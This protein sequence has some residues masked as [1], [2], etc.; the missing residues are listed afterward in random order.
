ML[1]RREAFG[2]LAAGMGLAV[3]RPGWAARAEDDK[4][5]RG[6]I[7][8]NPVRNPR[9]PAGPITGPVAIDPADGSWTQVVENMYALGVSTDGRFVYGINGGNQPAG[10]WSVDLKE[11]GEPRKIADERADRVWST[12]GGKIILST[13]AFRAQPRKAWRINPDGSG[14]EDLPIPDTDEVI[15]ASADGRWLLTR[16]DRGAPKEGSFLR[17][18]RAIYRMRPDGGDECLVLEA[19]YF[20]ATHRL[21]P[22]G[23]TVIYHHIEG[24]TFEGEKDFPKSSIWLVGS[25]GKGRRLLLKNPPGERYSQAVWSPDSKRLAVRLIRRPDDLDEEVKILPLY[26]AVCRIDVVDLEGKRLERVPV[27]EE[28]HYLLVDWR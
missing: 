17:E 19:G 26:R 3:A 15:D 12:V 23:R 2:R 24:D 27:P 18:R 22:D 21:S 28:F 7:F 4:E 20:S 14:R 1:T 6:R 11:G 8:I 10:T 16:S 13:F 9:G 5:S 25:D